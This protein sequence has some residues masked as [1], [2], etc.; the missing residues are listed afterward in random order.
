MKIAAKLRAPQIIVL[1]ICCFILFLGW[2]GYRAATRGSEITDPDYYSKGLKY[3][4]TLVEEKAA[5]VLG[6]AFDFHLDGPTLSVRLLDQQQRPVIGGEATL[7]LSRPSAAVPTLF[8]LTEAQPGIYQLTLP[9]DL[10]GEHRA[11]L[12]VHKE[13]AR[14][15]RNLLLNL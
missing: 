3:N 2:S 15:N 10:R 14:A 5:S 8:L 11:R 13:G 1:L 9:A 4:T 6:W 12:E 7:Y